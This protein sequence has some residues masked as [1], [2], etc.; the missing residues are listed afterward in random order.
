LKF[1]I[2][3]TNNWNCFDEYWAMF[4]RK[5]LSHECNVILGGNKGIYS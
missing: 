3:F 4:L 5:M 2:S 1:K